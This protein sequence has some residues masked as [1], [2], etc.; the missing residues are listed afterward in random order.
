MSANEGYYSMEKSLHYLYDET[1]NKF[2]N[3]SL[4]MIIEE[5]NILKENIVF[6]SEKD[7]LNIENQLRFALSKRVNT[8]D[9]KTAKIRGFIQKYS[10]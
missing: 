5:N 10:Q 9:S 7:L 6:P 3:D 4:Q 2:Y 8:I 1:I